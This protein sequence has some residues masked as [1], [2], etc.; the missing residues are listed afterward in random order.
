MKW[1]QFLPRFRAARH[2]LTEMEVREQWTRAQ[3]E[4]FQLNRLN[5]LWADVV[6]HVPYYRDLAKRQP[7]PRKFTSLSHFQSTIPIVDKSIV[8]GRCSEFLSEKAAKG[9]WY[10]SG[11]STGV[12]ASYFRSNAAHL[13]CLRGRY[14][15]HQMWDIDLFDRWVFLWGHAASFAPGL[16]GRIARWKQPVLDRLRNRLRLSAYSLGSEQLRSHLQRIATFRP[17]GIYAY[18]TAAYLLAREAKAIKFHCPSLKL[19]VLTAEPAFPHIVEACEDAFGVPAVAEYGAVEANAMAFE[20]PD[21]KL[22]VREDLVSLETLRRSDGRYDIV[23]TALNSNSFP[24]IRYAI[25][26][27]TDSPAQYPEVGFAHLANV[28]GRHQDLIINNAG[29]PLFAGWFEDVLEYNDSIRRYQVHQHDSGHLSVILELTNPKATVDVAEV[30]RKFQDKSGFSVDVSIVEKMP[31]SRAG[32]HRWITSDMAKKVI[33][34]PPI[35]TPQVPVS[36]F[37]ETN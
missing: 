10:H 22:R 12:P 30:K 4:E 33:A 3:I 7:L 15:A 29:E 36:N 24:L 17:V 26:D 35:D 20:W 23:V 21:R 11:G 32:K 9:K 16:P 5:S 34:P 28:A 27:V 18:S 1:L 37:S 14:R 2:A 19:V 25:G 31:A 8:N 6:V 13:E